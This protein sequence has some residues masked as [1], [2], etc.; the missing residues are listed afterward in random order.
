MQE[1]AIRRD[2][3]LVADDNLEMARSVADGLRERGYHAAAV[4][5]GR[6][7]LER[8]ASESFDALVTDLRMPEIDGLTL[9]ARSLS[10]DPDRPIIAMTASSAIDIAL[11]SLRQG[12]YQYV[13]KPFKQE[14]L[15]ILLERAL[16]QAR[17][18][19]GARTLE[20]ALR[21]YENQAGKEGDGQLVAAAEMLGVDAAI[22]RRWLERPI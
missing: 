20:N 21:R 13:T 2:S 18:K 6:E 19:R 17:L 7:A 9:I 16:H 4:G 15:A 8:L 14:E 12:A 3:I 11:E 5:S 1:T 22:L 10:Q